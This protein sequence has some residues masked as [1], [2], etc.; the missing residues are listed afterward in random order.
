VGF[1]TGN[2]REPR[3]RDLTVNLALLIT[4]ARTG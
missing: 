1:Y 2:K 4:H 3:M